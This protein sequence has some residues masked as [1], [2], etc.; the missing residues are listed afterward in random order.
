MNL[1]M[2]FLYFILPIQSGQ[3]YATCVKGKL[4]VIS[5]PNSLILSGIHPRKQLEPLF[6]SNLHKL[7]T[8]LCF[9]F[10]V[11]L[12]FLHQETHLHPPRPVTMS[13]AAHAWGIKI[14]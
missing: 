11:C 2:Y 3:S 4:Q 14:S 13:M 7:G 6:L 8:V 9:N 1:M 10:Y 12:F 5:G